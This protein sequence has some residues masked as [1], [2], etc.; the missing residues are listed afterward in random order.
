[1]SNRNLIISCVTLVLIIGVSSVASAQ[2]NGSFRFR[3]GLFEPSADSSYW[4]EKFDVWTGESEDFQDLVWAGDFLWM[5]AYSTLGV[6]FG[7]SWYQGSTRQSYRDWVDGA[8]GEVSHWTELTTWDLTVAGVFKP[9]P[10]SSVR[11]YFGLGGG[12]IS[13]RLVESGDFID[14]GSPNND[15]VYAVYGDDGTTFEFF[16]LAGVEFN[17]PGGWLIFLEGRWRDADTSLGGGFGSLGQRL[18]LSGYEVT[19]G[20]GFNF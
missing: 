15:I 20:F 7:G 18:D 9:L 1:M 8:G 4:D 10:S 16:G 3:M 5:P 2:S 12:L 19:A 6:Q 13:Y 17:V 11:P 14:F